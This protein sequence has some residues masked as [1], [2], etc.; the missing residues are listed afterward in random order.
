M[1]ARFHVA[2]S[3]AAAAPASLMSLALPLVAPGGMVVA[4]VRN[5]AQ[6]AV[7]CRDAARTAGGGDPLVHPACL[8]VT[9]LFGD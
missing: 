1:R 7:Q 9:K 3:R 2:F 5:P 8:V 4:A 6:A